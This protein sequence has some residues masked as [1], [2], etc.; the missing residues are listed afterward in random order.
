VPVSG[1]TNFRRWNVFYTQCSTEPLPDA[2]FS[3]VWD[4]LQPWGIFGNYSGQYHP[5]S[6]C[7]EDFD[8]G[9]V[10]GTW[11]LRVIDVSQFGSGRVQGFQ[12]IFCNDEGVDC[13]ECQLDP[14]FLISENVE[15]C[16]SSSLFTLEDHS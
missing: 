5:F 2:G 8:T 11:T 10:N 4:N 6:G 9:P 1:N 13:N 7:L 16:E 15:K 14:G 12:L 3:S